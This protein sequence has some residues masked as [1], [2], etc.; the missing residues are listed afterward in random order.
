[1]F[2]VVADV[3]RRRPVGGVSS[4]GAVM[5][6]SVA[7]AQSVMRLEECQTVAL[8]LALFG[9]RLSN[10]CALFAVSGLSCLPT[11]SAN[12]HFHDRTTA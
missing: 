2:G 8:C 10:L 11:I 7:S 3:S 12:A 6:A 5:V 9:Q 4:A 1:M